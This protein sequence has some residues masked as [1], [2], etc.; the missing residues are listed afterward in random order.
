MERR[1]NHQISQTKA[2]TSIGFRIMQ[3]WPRAIPQGVVRTFWLIMLPRCLHCDRNH[4]PCTC[5]PCFYIISIRFAFICCSD[6]FANPKIRVASAIIKGKWGGG[7]A[8]RISPLFPE[9]RFGI[10]AGVHEEEQNQVHWKVAVLN[11]I[12]RICIM[13]FIPR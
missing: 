10:I 3:Y 5:C 11:G 12:K 7:Y 6:H 2:G 8:D 9:S 1:S 4:P 13:Q